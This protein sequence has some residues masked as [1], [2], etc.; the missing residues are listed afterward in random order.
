MSRV[1]ILDKKNEILE[2]ISQNQ[3]KAFICKKLKCR[4][5]TLDSYLKKMGIDYIGNR[6]GKSV[7]NSPYKKTAYELS[8]SKLYVSS[9]KYKLRLLEEGIRKHQCEIC[10]IAEWMGKPA[11]LELH[12]INGNRFDNRFEN[13]QIL[14]PNCHSQTPNYGR[15]I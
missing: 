9:H 14:C 8:Q 4:P 11:P 5:S 13:V 6:G 7:K 3:P 1:D 2:L 15:N 12:H 10:G